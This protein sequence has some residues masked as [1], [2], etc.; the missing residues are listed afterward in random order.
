MTVN[1]GKKRKNYNDKSLNIVKSVR[2][3][4]NGKFRQKPDKAGRSISK[5]QQIQ[6][7]NKIV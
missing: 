6:Q 3:S 7:K 1:N 4:G 2:V 5:N